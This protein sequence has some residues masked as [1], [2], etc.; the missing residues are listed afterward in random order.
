[1]LTQIEIGKKIAVARKLKNLSQAQLAARLAVSAQAVGKWERGE[2]VPDIFMFRRIA[3]ALDTNLQYLAGEEADASA[4]E[5]AGPS[6]AT[7]AGEAPERPG[8][9]LSGGRWADA[10]FSGLSGLAE[11]FSG[12]N[13]ERCQFVGSE[14]SGL[15]MKGN[16]IRG[17]DFS[18]S[19]LSGCRFSGVKMEHDAFAG[20]DFSGSVFSGSHMADCDLSGADL[21]DLST[22]WSHFKKVRLDGA[23]LSRTKFAFGQLTEMTFTGDLTECAF[24]N[25][26]FTR[27]TFDGARLYRCF[28]K[29][30]KL[31]RAKFINCQADR[32]TYAFLKACKANLSDVTVHEGSDAS[33]NG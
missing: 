27:V 15:T 28:F 18:R 1:M 16:H 17:S 10:D 33:P 30:A 11:R 32:L 25:C 9:N 7:G 8:W 19:D 29:N 23:V 3:A 20:S 22:K 13:I 26:D 12:A 31:R 21:T 5:P 2:S 6:V 14:L 24:E 4:P